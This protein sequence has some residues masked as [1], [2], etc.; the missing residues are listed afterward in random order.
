M[1][2][3]R[4]GEVIGCNLNS[5]L[6]VT[7]DSILVAVVIKGW[8]IIYCVALANERYNQTLLISL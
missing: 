2:C 1:L 8:M 3:I 6:D 4:M 5:I 7:L